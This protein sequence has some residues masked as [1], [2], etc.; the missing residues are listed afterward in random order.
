MCSTRFVDGQNDGVR[1]RIDIEPNHVAQFVDEMRV[2]R[3]LELASP[4]RLKTMDAPDSMDGTD[5]ET[6]AFAIEAPVQWVAS[7][8]WSRRRIAERQ[9]D[10]ALTVGW[11]SRPDPGALAL[12][13]LPRPR[14]Q[15]GDTWVLPRTL[16]MMASR[17]RSR[18]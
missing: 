11:E 18:D 17:E 15:G 14:E 2:A 4:V 16:W 9:G 5:A 6:D 12:I 7:N 13:L 1:R 3:E 8:G 10:N